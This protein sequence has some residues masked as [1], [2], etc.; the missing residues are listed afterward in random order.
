MM[1][2]S[3]FTADYP[4]LAKE[5]LTKISISVPLEDVVVKGDPRIIDT[6]ALWDT[7][8]TGSAIT[9][10]TVEKLGIKPI[11][12]AKVNHAGGCTTTNVY[13]VDIYLPNNMRARAVRVTEC[14]D[15][16]GSFGVLIGMDIIT[17]GDF[18]L[19]N[20]GGRTTISFRVPSLERID[21][22]SQTK[23]EPAKA[24]AKIGRNAP[25]PCGSRKK[26]KHCCGKEN[27]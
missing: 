16:A 20:V 27:K 13:L 12:T 1:Q 3:S 19:T 11:S 15:A 26:Y 7:G 21:Y 25:C 4:V 8:A 6:S 22:V 5:I 9:T 2:H 18:S 10:A 14:D 23:I 17:A 24:D